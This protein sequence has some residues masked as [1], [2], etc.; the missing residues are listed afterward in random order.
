MGASCHG[1][2][3][4]GATR[5]RFLHSRAE[6]GAVGP[7][8]AGPGP[9]RLSPGVSR[10]QAQ[11]AG[12][13][14][15][16]LAPP[17]QAGRLRHAAAGRPPWPGPASG[18]RPSHAGPRGPRRGGG[19]RGRAGTHHVHDLQEAQ[20][21][22]DG[23]RLRVIG[24]RPLQG[25]VVPHQ[26]LVELPLELALQGPWAGRAGGRSGEAAGAPDAPLP[27]IPASLPA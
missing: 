27:A 16:S 5:G 9:G 15:A 10:H 23:E 18:W 25:V 6:M 2:W 8:L 21:E 7:A 1:K 26:L 12:G 19:S 11:V 20:R 17:W 24:H 14:A 3:L 4:D 13:G 22:V